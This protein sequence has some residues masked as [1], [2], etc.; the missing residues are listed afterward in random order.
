MEVRVP[1]APLVPQDRLGSLQLE[2]QEC[3]VYQESQEQEDSMV[4]KENLDL[5]DSQEQEGHKGPPALPAPQ[6]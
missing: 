4:R 5:L 6:D 2:S 3:Q 1:K